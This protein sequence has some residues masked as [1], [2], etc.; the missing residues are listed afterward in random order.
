MY[1]YLQTLGYLEI[2][3]VGFQLPYTVTCVI[4][5][6]TFDNQVLVAPTPLSSVDVFMTDAAITNLTTL[7]S[8]QES[9]L[10]DKSPPMEKSNA[11]V[12]D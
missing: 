3:R 12:S 10:L 2:K 8:V 4:P 6:Q 5:S 11:Q 7:A 1:L 9:V